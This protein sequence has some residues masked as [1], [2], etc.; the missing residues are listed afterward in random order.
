MKCSESEKRANEQI[1]TFAFMPSFIVNQF[2]TLL[3]SHTPL[4]IVGSIDNLLCRRINATVS[5]ACEG[6]E[7]LHLRSLLKVLS[8]TAVDVL[9]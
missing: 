8:E 4:I 1:E 2:F 5:R 3:T 9:A 6:K 7:T